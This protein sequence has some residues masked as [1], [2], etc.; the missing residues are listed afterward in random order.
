MRVKQSEIHTNGP[1]RMRTGH[2]NRMRWILGRCVVA[3]VKVQKMQECENAK[4]KIRK[5]AKPTRLCVCTKCEAKMQK[6]ENARDMWVHKMQTVESRNAR[7]MWDAWKREVSEMRNT[8]NMQDA[9]NAKYAK[10]QK[11]EN[12]KSWRS[13]RFNR[14]SIRSC[15]MVCTRP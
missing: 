2:A 13:P 11:C 12:A 3:H 7:N 8:W 9:Q 14:S 10:T 1:W 15:D 5:N 6:H 4:C